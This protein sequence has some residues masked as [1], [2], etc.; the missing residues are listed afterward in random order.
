M[1][2]SKFSTSF[3]DDDVTI[4]IQHK[5][6]N[7]SRFFGPTFYFDDEG[8]LLITGNERETFKYVA[9]HIKTT[10]AKLKKYLEES[11]E[12]ARIYNQIF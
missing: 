12:D 7:E 1:L 11:Y 2:H 9:R 3:G 10:I 8:K 6:N 5:V 4:F